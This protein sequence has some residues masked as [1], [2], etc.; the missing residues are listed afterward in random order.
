M[1]SL[2]LLINP[3]QFGRN[4]I[5]RCIL[6]TT[7]YRIS[8]HQNSHWCVK[9]KLRIFEAV[10]APITILITRIHIADLPVHPYHKIIDCSASAFL[11]RAVFTRTFWDIDLNLW[12]IKC[13]LNYNKYRYGTS[14]VKRVNYFFIVL[15][16][17]VHLLSSA[18]RS[19]MK[20]LFHKI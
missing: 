20:V 12:H 3:V 7:V 15:L 2:A 18:G 6:K 5:D 1:S 8:C 17:A 13:R 11:S 10:W 14:I 16:G 9:Y 19:F 4:M